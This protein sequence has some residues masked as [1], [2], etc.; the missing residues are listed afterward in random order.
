[1]N[2]KQQ[3]TLRSLLKKYKYKN[4][5]NLVRQ[6]MGINFENLLLKAEPLY[7]VPRIA[8]CYGDEK[9]R[10]QMMDMMYK[11]WL[12]DVVEKRWVEPLNDL[13]DEYGDRVLLQAIYYLLDNNL[14]EVYEGRVALDDGKAAYEGKLDDIPTAVDQVKEL[15]PELAGKKEEEKP[16]AD[17]NEIVAPSSIMNA[18]EAIAVMGEIG[19]TSARLQDQIK[20][21]E[22]YI[23]TSADPDASARK[24]NEQ[25]KQIEDLQAKIAEMQKKAAEASE[26]MKKASDYISKLRGEIDEVQDDYD[27]LNA[28]YKKVL[29]ERDEADKELAACQ[30]LLEEEAQKE[31]LPKKKIIPQSV[32][33]DVPLLGKGVMRGLLPVLARYN[34]SVDPNR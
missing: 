25:Q 33:E 29:D 9:Q 1:M 14:W 19:G 17:A 13:A 3:N 4:A 23:Y 30:K 28:K 10:K 16:S 31:Q 2:T 8:S 22:D 6:A 20:R 24:I 32:L 5:S 27:V 26:T 21:L 34:I 11:E 7:I 15:N 18:D 12:K